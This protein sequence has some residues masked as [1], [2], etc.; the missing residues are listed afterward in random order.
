MLYSPQPLREK[1]TLFWHN[2]F[3]T[4]NRKV[5]NAGYMLGQYELMRRHALGNFRTLLHRDIHRPGHAG[6]A[7]HRQQQR[8]RQP[9]ENY[10]RELME[11]FSLG[12]RPLHRTR[13]P[14]GRPCLHRLEPRRGRAVFERRQ[15]DDGEKTVLGQRGRW[16]ADDIVRLCLEQEAASVFPRS[17]AVSLPGQRDHRPP[18]ADLLEP[19]AE[20]FRASDYDFGALVETVLRVRTCSSRRRPIA[21]RSKAPVDFALG[22]V[23]GLEG[24]RTQGNGQRRLGTVDWLRPRRSRARRSSIRRRSPAGTAAGPGS[25]VKRFLLRQNL[26]LALTSTADD[27]F[28][29]RTDPAALARRHE[30][31][32]RCRAGRILPACSCKAIVPAATRTRLLD[33]SKSRRRS[34]IRSTGLPRTSPTSACAAAPPGV[35]LAGV[36]AVLFTEPATSGGE[37]P[38]RLSVVQLV[39]RT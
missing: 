17:Q 34:R 10:A 15:H 22:I 24:H 11:L 5:Q 6:L 14:R 35:V 33:I 30:A 28:G 19:L 38:P 13:H 18:T 23:R 29:R 4:S 1:M 32:Y 27:R 8:Q 39:V 25:M 26:A 9:N 20:E 7:R 31:S 37:L 36:S 21:A 16:Q 12:H 2:H 3:A